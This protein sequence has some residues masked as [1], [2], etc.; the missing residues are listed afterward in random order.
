MYTPT[1]NPLPW[2]TD[3]LRRAGA[4]DKV[5]EDVEGD[6]VRDDSTGKWVRPK[7]S[8]TRVSND[9]AVAT[10]DILTQTVSALHDDAKTYAVVL[11][12]T[13]ATAG[14]L[15]ERKVVEVGSKPMSDDTLTDG[16][17]AAIMAGLALHEVGH[18]RYGRM[19]AGAVK[20]RF[21]EGVTGAISALSNLA[22]DVHDEAHVMNDFPGLAP[23]IDVTLWYV[24]GKDEVKPRSATQGLNESAQQRV[25]LA[26]AAVRY[27][28]TVAWDSNSAR[29]WLDWW[30]DWAT[31]AYAADAP[32]QHAEV[33]AE[34]IAK[35]RAFDPD[36]KPEK[37]QGP[38]PCG[39]E[40][41]PKKSDGQQPRDDEQPK[42]DEPEGESQPGG[43]TEDGDE[44]GKG[45]GKDDTGDDEDGE[46]P[47]GGDGGDEPDT[48]DGDEPGDETGGEGASLGGEYSDDEDRPMDDP[49]PKD[50]C[51]DRLDTMLQQGAEYVTRGKREG[52]RI[53]T[54]RHRG[55]SWHQSHRVVSHAR[56]GGR[57]VDADDLLNR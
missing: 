50:A 43:D 3:R 42:A 5:T 20:R 37:P 21:P 40:G 6:W 11:S 15:L 9:A 46:E 13:A 36:P 53:R 26:I 54:Y 47:S 32:K 8:R 44:D 4:F 10:L 18:I 29:E 2:V 55:P 31:R 34:A 33:V 35:V 51:A 12:K 22:A 16:Q 1:A 7:T 57:W 48:E 23:A 24:G 38:P 56:K 39:P 49:C 41:P 30:R 28:W 14:T 52:L 17:K 45:K 19:W 25:N 27:D